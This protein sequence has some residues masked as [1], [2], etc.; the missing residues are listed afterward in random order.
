MANASSSHLLS[1]IL[2]LQLP[3]TLRS[4]LFP[5]TSFRDNQSSLLKSNIFFPYNLLTLISIEKNYNKKKSHL[6]IYGIPVFIVLP[7]VWLQE[8]ECK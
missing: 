4:H 7:H 1:F 2:D 8:T 6:D 5:P 3:L